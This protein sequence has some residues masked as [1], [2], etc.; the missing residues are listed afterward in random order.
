IAAALIIGGA[1]AAIWLM[2]RFAPYAITNAS[3]GGSNI[4]AF[5][6]SLTA[7][8]EMPEGAAYPA[9]LS[10]RIGRPIINAGVSGDT[11][12][13]GLRRLERDVLER[14]PRIVLLCLGGNDILRNRPTDEIIGNLEDI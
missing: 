9:Q 14:D 13:D 11:T 3:P 2:G 12:A 6:D 4:I 7:G 1:L 10:Q 8:Y 5:G